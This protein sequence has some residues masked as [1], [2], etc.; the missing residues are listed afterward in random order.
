MSALRCAILGTDKYC[1]HLQTSPTGG[2][3]CGER[4]CNSR[5]VRHCRRGSR[6]E[7]TRLSEVE[8]ARDRGRATAIPSNSWRDGM[9][10]GSGNEIGASRACSA[11]YM[12]EN[13]EITSFA[14]SACSRRAASANGGCSQTR[15]ELQAT[16]PDRLA[17]HLG[18]KGCNLMVRALRG[19]SSDEDLRAA[20]P[21]AVELAMPSAWIP[22]TPMRRSAR[23][24]RS[25]RL[26]FRRSLIP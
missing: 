8:R 10:N 9:G 12:S 4:C 24:G 6:S 5:R 13:Q 15:Y 20:L 19:L 21:R 18:E 2:G 23:N 16:I 22:R 26:P 7:C 17:S 1:L 11:W 3:S 14:A 25:G